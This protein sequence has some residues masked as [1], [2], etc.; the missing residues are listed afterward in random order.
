MKNINMSIEEKLFWPFKTATFRTV[1][2]YRHFSDGTSRYNDKAELT[3]VQG[4]QFDVFDLVV[5]ALSSKSS[6]DVKTAKDMI[7]RVFAEAAKD[8]IRYVHELGTCNPEIKEDII[9]Y[10][11]ENL[12]N[13][14]LRELNKFANFALPAEKVGYFIDKVRDVLNGKWVDIIEDELQN[15]VEELESEQSCGEGNRA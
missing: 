3:Q 13:E 7:G 14:I 9:R 5:L 10:C 6:A 11:Y 15:L 2:R 8:Y 12:M 4:V 1:P